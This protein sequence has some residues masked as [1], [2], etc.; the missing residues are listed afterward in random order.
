M[1]FDQQS[2]EPRPIEGCIDAVLLTHNLVKTL[3]LL[4]IVG[5]HFCNPLSHLDRF[6]LLQRGSGSHDVVPDGQVARV[7]ESESRKLMMPAI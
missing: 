1:Y 2:T 6:P 7:I 5:H 3:L 4:Q